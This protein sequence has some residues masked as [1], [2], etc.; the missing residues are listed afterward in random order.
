CGG[1]RV[2]ASLLAVPGAALYRITSPGTSVDPSR[3]LDGLLY[4]ARGDHIAFVAAYAGGAAPVRLARHGEGAVD[5]RAGEA[6]PVR[7]RMTE[8]GLH[9]E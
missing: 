3:R 9:R 4:R 2:T 6:T 1:D 8:Q 5:V 7:F